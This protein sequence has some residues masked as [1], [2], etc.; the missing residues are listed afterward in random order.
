LAEEKKRDGLVSAEENDNELPLP[1]R[2]GSTEKKQKNTEE[3]SVL[4]EE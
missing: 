2:G 1:D 4:A 3:G